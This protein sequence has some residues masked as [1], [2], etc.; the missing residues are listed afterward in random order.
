MP[1]LRQRGEIGNVSGAPD[2][3]HIDLKGFQK[4]LVS[5]FAAPGFPNLGLM[6]H[7]EFCALFPPGVLG[8]GPPYRWFDPPDSGG[9]MFGEYVGILGKKSIR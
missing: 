7:K 4:Y 3:D 6:N 5:N 2:L 9:E 8:I 1:L